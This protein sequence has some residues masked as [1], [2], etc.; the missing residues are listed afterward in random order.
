MLHAFRPSFSRA[1]K[2]GGGDWKPVSKRKKKITLVIIQKVHFDGN[3][4]SEEKR[5]RMITRWQSSFDS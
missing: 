2:K 5:I 1:S 3:P 4:E